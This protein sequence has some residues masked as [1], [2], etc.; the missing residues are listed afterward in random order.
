[1]HWLP[2][3]QGE[4]QTFAIA[5]PSFTQERPLQH[6]LALQ[7]CPAELHVGAAQN[8]TGAQTAPPPLCN[9]VQHPLE[10]WLG[11]VQFAEHTLAPES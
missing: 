4:A 9:G 11:L 5:M 1:M 7:P 6:A 2:A 8:V 10:H 3:V